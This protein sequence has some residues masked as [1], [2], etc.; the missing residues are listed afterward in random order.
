MNDNPSELWCDGG[1]IGPNPSRLGGTWCFCAIYQGERINQ[2]WGICT[3]DIM[4]T[5][6]IT[7]NQTELLAAL[8]ALESVPIDWNGVLYTDS[9]ITQGR[10][11]IGRKFAGIPDW[12]RKRVLKRREKHKYRV[13]LVGG[14]PT[15]NELLSGLRKDGKIVSKWNVWCD[16]RCTQLAK[17]VQLEKSA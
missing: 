17:N 3:P 6:T 13:Q 10:I 15:K 9:K 5:E 7:N 2:D 8:M 11:T 4:K 16:K 12:L 14:H 1:V